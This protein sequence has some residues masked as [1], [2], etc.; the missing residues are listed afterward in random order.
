MILNLLSKAPHCGRSPPRA[1]LLTTAKVYVTLA[2][3]ALSVGIVLAFDWIE[4]LVA[5]L[6]DWWSHW[7]PKHYS[8][9]CEASWAVSDYVYGFAPILA[10]FIDALSDLVQTCLRAFSWDPPPTLGSVILASRPSFIL[11][12]SWCRGCRFGG[13]L[14]ILA[15]DLIRSSRN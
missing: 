8:P 5:R 7:G 13:I 2:T 3:I 4:R 1:F 11:L 10:A 12:A 15:A 14:R 9:L 6:F